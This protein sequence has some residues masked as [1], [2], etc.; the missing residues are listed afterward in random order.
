MDPLHLCV[1]L[2]PL[3]IYLVF[4]AVINLRRR[5][6]LLNGFRDSAALALG[7]NGLVAAGP[8]ELFLPERAAFHFGPYVWFLLLA[9]YCLTVA[10]F[11]LSMR[12]RLVIYNISAEELRPVL[13]TVIQELDEG[14]RW[15]G[16]NVVMPNLGVQLH[17]DRQPTFRNIQIVASGGEQSFQGWGKLEQALRRA[18]QSTRTN[19]SWHG[20]TYLLAASL[21]LA[22]VLSSLLTERESIAQALHEMLRM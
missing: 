21:M 13:A 22:T 14:S 4:I 3:A 7:L 6:F 8:L 9:L 11:I 19:R 20:L 10:L 15:A 17:L 2:V 16:E 12:P 18:L 1:A 5:P